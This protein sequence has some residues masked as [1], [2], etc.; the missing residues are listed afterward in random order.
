MTPK[1]TE[2]ARLRAAG[3]GK[4]QAAKTAGYAAGSAKV[5]ASRM[6]K[7]PEILAAI[8][9]GRSSQASPAP[10]AGAP[11]IEFD[12]AESYLAAV[13]KGLTLP[14]PVRVGAARALLPYEKGKQRAPVK[15]ATPRQLD[16]QNKL[17][18]EQELL[19]K[20]AEKAAQVRER[21]KRE[22]TA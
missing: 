16:S 18:A 13:V 9:A 12:S 22:Q 10:P 1:Q 8:A 17:I 20:W 2:Y 4:A 11:D 5:V 6:E 14:D 7:M 21:L 15:S 3:L 19:D